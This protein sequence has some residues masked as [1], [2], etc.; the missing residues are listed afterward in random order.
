MSFYFSK[1]YYFHCCMKEHLIPQVLAKEH[2]NSRFFHSCNY[3]N[4]S[5]TKSFRNHNRVKLCLITIVNF[6]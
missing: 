4:C 3:I 6:N 2:Y 5:L 1:A